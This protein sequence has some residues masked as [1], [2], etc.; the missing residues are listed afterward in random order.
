MHGCAKMTRDPKQSS[1]AKNTV[2][3]ERQNVT[4]LSRDE[5]K[6]RGLGYSNV[7]LLRLESEGKFPKRIYLSPARVAWLEAEIVEYVERCINARG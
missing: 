3:A 2:A 1:S 6:R 7:H 4:F 5:L